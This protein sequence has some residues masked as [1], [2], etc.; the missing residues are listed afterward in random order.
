MN[1]NSNTIGQICQEHRVFI[2][3]RELNN[4]IVMHAFYVKKRLKEHFIVKQL[5]TEMK[6]KIEIRCP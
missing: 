2:I 4:I 5:R 1:D 6:M 3:F